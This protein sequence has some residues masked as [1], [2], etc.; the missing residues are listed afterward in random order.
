MFEIKELTQDELD[1]I[2]QRLEAFDNDHMKHPMEGSISIGAYDDQGVLIAG[3]DACMTAHRILYVSTV[4]VEPAY[5]R[6][7]IGRCLMA[8]VERRAK[9]LGANLIRLDTFDWQGKAF[10]ESIG[11]EIVGQYTC[12]EDGYSEYFFLK[13]V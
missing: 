8:Q 7:G 13:R 6:Q 10:Y 12:E 2:E 3:A 11:Y 1:S 9:D 4:F 5:R